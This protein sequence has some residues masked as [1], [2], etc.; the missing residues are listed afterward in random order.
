M[1]D[2]YFGLI[3]GFLAA[4]GLAAVFLLGILEEIIFFLPSSLVFVAVG[5]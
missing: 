3:E 5:F 2:Q 4:Y 1:I